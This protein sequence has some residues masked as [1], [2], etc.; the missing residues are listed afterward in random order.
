VLGTGEGLAGGDAVAHEVGEE[1]G[2]DGDGS[3]ELPL[4]GGELVDEELLAGSGGQVL[5]GE[6]GAKVVE[7]RG[8]LAGQDDGFAGEAVGEAIEGDAGFALGGAGAGG[9]LGVAAVGGDLFVG[10]MSIPA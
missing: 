10:A 6:G 8:V 9:E 7:V 5:G 3:G 4:I 1:L 2:V